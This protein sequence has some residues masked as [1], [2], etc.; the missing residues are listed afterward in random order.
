LRGANAHFILGNNKEQMRAKTAKK[1]REA[2]ESIQDEVA[3][4]MAPRI[5]GPRSRENPLL[6]LSIPK[7]IFEE[8]P[9]RSTTQ[10]CIT[11]GTIPEKKPAARIWRGSRWL[12][13]KVVRA[14]RSAS[15]PNDGTR[16]T[17]LDLT[18]S[19]NHAP[20][21]GVGIP[22]TIKRLAIKEATLTS[23]L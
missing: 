16:T 4:K 15:A 2:N 22:I 23:K 1:D 3:F 5:S 14:N 7:P 18:L 8:G 9:S 10:M 19:E 17:F 12:G 21:I 13:V 6:A 20:T 11:A